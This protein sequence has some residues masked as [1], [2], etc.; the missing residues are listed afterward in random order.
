M[1]RIWIQDHRPL[2]SDIATLSKQDVDKAVTDLKMTRVDSEA[3]ADL[4]FCH[5]SYE[6]IC[7]VTGW[8]AFDLDGLDALEDVVAALSTWP[9][10]VSPVGRQIGSE[11]RDKLRQTQRNSS[12]AADVAARVLASLLE[13][14]AL[15]AD[16]D[17]K[18]LRDSGASDLL[19]S[20]EGKP[21]R[22]ESYLVNRRIIEH[23]VP[24]L[25]KIDLP[26]FPDGQITIMVTTQ[27]GYEEVFPYLHTKLRLPGRMRHVLFA[28]DMAQFK[29]DRGLLKEILALKP[30]VA[31]SIVES[32]MVNMPVS[33]AKLFAPAPTDLLQSLLVLS[34][35]YLCSNWEAQDSRSGSTA[36]AEKA[37]HAAQKDIALDSMLE[38]LGP[39]AAEM[40]RG[41]IKGQPQVRSPEW[42][43]KGLGL[44]SERTPSHSGRTFFEL[45][46]SK[47]WCEDRFGKLPRALAEL[48]KC[49]ELGEE[50]KSPGQIAEI[51]C[52]LVNRVLGRRCP[53]Y[54]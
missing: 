31:E 21:Q 16:F 49:I 25:P 24:A 17:E 28:R 46:L 41:L 4:L 7:R 30:E 45:S 34:L 8:F 39:R 42:W 2:A 19:L 53:E 14:P 22:G 47:Q 33:T 51:Y 27:S 35:A 52:E 44:G 15:H 18:I 29:S 38:S 32:K 6:K 1:K 36:A 23:L 43:R 26:D 40:K 11:L 3:E 12:E 48:V 5:L 9:S 13:R 10:A 50:I 20:M 54:S 37:L